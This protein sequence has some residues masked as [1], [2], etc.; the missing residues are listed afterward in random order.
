MT[1]VGIFGSRETGSRVARL[2]AKAGHERLCAMGNRLLPYL[3]HQ[4]ASSDRAVGVTPND[5][6]DLLSIALRGPISTFLLGQAATFYA[7]GATREGENLSW[8]GF[9]NHIGASSTGPLDI[10]AIGRAV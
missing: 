2:L 3:E 6:A 4:L 7:Q 8:K 9:I 5:F 1:R 10:R